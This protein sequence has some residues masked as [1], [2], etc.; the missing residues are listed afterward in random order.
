[1]SPPFLKQVRKSLIKNIPQNYPV[2]R[3]FKLRNIVLKITLQCNSNCI[4]CQ[5]RR[6]KYKEIM[7]KKERTMQLSD[8]EKLF[9]DAK[10]IGLKRVV[11]S[12]GEPTLSPDCIEIIGL[13]KG[14][15]LCCIL[16]TNG[17]N[18]GKIYKE[19]LNMGIDEVVLSLDSLQSKIHNQ[20]RR[21]EGLWERAVAA[22]NDLNN[23]KKEKRFKSRI[24]IRSILTKYFLEDLDQL[25]NFA[26]RYGID[27]WKL[28]YVEADYENKIF[29]PSESDIKRWQS[30]G[31]PKMLQAINSSLYSRSKKNNLKEEVKKIFYLPNMSEKEI[32]AG[33]YRKNVSECDCP[34]YFALIYPNGDIW[35][36]IGLD[37]R[38]DHVMGNLF[39]DGIVNIFR[40]KSYRDMRNKTIDW[41]VYCPDNK[42]VLETAQ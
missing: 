25:I 34:E 5:M 22:L 21:C 27:S 37:Y 28:D 39:Y 33:I 4:A 7:Q 15:N 35:P 38:K 12:G 14:L 16:N 24:T 6:E 11:I 3:L 18:L 20:L 40:N 8:Y 17:F 29:L 36:C 2:G 41:C 19:I 31:L 23:F 30:E 13:I 26:R 42:I 9:G 1:M 10:K 32:S